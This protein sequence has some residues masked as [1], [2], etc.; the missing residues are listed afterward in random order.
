MN[1]CYCYCYES[2]CVCVMEK[3][4]SWK[5]IAKAILFFSAPTGS[6]TGVFVVLTSSS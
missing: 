2:F 1:P 3:K 6:T 4:T 5:A